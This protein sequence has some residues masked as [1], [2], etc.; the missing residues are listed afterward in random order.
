MDARIL[1]CGILILALGL[2]LPL[3]HAQNTPHIG[4]LYPAGGQQGR[5]FAVTVG[6]QFLDGATNVHASGA[7]IQTRVVEHVKPLTPNQANALREQA[8]ELQ[9]RKAAATR[10]ARRAT[11]RNSLS[12][13]NATWTTSDEKKLADIRHKL[14][15][16]QRRPTNPAIAE[17]VRL[18][19]T[20]APDA[21]PGERE[22][23]LRTAQGLSNPLV[24]CVGYLPEYCEKSEAAAPGPAQG[25]R[26]LAIRAAPA[27][28]AETP[29]QITLPAVVN[30]QILPGDTDRFQFRARQHQE[31]VVT[32]SAQQLIPYLPDAVPGWFQAAIALHNAEGEELAFVDDYR[33]HPDPVLHHT[34]PEDGTYII[35]IRD[36]IYRG[37]E[38]FVYRI[39]LGELPF[40]TA[41]FPLGGAA[42]TSTTVQ[43]DGW[44]LPADK[45]DVTPSAPGIHTL[46]VDQ[47]ARRS[48]RLPFA[49]DTLPEHVE[50]EPNNE[51]GRAQTV[52]PGLVVN[53][54]IDPPG[55]VD[56]FSFPGQAGGTIVAEVLA[57]R[58]ESPLDSLLELTDVAGRRL[59]LND[60]HEDKGAG[61]FTHHADSRLTATLP[62]NGTYSLHLRDTQRQG[63]PE[64]AYRLRISPPRPD[65]ELRIVPAN[66][67]FRAGS[68][69][70][71]T[72]YALRKDNF[73]GEIELL[74][75]EPT[76]T[77]LI[78]GSRI[79]AG[80][81]QL[82]FTL[83]L[84]R[85]PGRLPFPIALEGRALIE[86]REARRPGVPAEDQMQ[87]FAYR[88]LVPARDM[89]A[90]VAGRAPPRALAG[91]AAPALVRI[92]AGGTAA[93]RLPFP[94]GRMADRYQFELSEPPE[95]LTL[96]RA[97]ANQRGVEL[98]LRCDALKVKPG[99]RGNL[100]VNTFVTPAPASSAATKPQAPRRRA[101][102]G[103]L[104]A[105]PFEVVA[106]P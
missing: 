56:V 11:A 51:I 94:A 25:A 97:S 81:D 6:G 32:V 89:L 98:L 106:R 10:A 99:A 27:P 48:N 78:G 53:G 33:F 62:A 35:E 67:N 93:A 61:L 54:R 9:E 75:R 96:E 18:E 73:T 16:F 69:V 84:T 40:I 55:D 92:P 30:G 64:F 105:I 52:T 71:A 28:P 100:I 8:K 22:L 85:I 5:S 43:L 49:A 45:L 39:T 70:L 80:Q 57:R 34:I 41:A 36:A 31:L 87:A 65:F 42:G 37:R 63:G 104:P 7:G 88:H 46:S 72:A 1:H 26:P 101:A 95:G 82:R 24:F 59:A 23:R 2:S 12:T 44:N 60:D 68:T 74:V 38:D 50:V 15:A 13:T 47:A 19:V 3:L 20:L 90:T 103:L 14:A 91:I 76:G 17:T 58:L 29:L 66:L 77:L 4:Y 21:E 102:A 83:T 79:P 86:G